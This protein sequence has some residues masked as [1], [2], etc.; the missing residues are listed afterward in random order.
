MLNIRQN[1]DARNGLGPL[2][3][4]RPSLRKG[5]SIRVFI[6]SGIEHG[7]ANFALVIYA[8][9]FVAHYFGGWLNNS[10]ANRAWLYALG[11][12]YEWRDRNAPNVRLLICDSD[13]IRNL[14]RG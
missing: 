11:F 4:N 13:R 10:T 9:T 3:C 7:R 6:A 2:N 14:A 1:Q 12:A 5:R 8:G